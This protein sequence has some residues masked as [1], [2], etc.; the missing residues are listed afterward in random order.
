MN[1][2]TTRPGHA[3]L[4]SIA[5]T[6]APALAP[7]L[8]F[9]KW[10]AYDPETQN[11][12]PIPGTVTFDTKDS[13]LLHLERVAEAVNGVAGSGA[14]RDWFS[15]YQGGLRGLGCAEPDRLR[16]RTLWRLVVGTA[17]NPALETG[18]TLH[19]LLGVPY[20]PGSAVKGLA[21]HVAEA[22][23]AERLGVPLEEPPDDET[24][25]P[26]PPT[27]EGA[28]TKLLDAA[29]RVRAVFG[30]L[31]VDRATD[32]RSG[33]PRGPHTGVSVLR[34]WQRDREAL[35]PAVRSQIRDLLEPTGGAVC[36]YDAV[37]VPGSAEA[38]AEVDVMTPHYPDYYSSKGGSP[39]SDDQDP[40]P[41]TF[42]AVAPGV[43]LAFPF[44]VR[45][46]PALAERL[47]S[48]QAAELAE[49]WLLHGLTTWGAGAKTAAGYGYFERTG[50]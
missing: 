10:H 17:T 46:T 1:E 36:F 24:M 3:G 2:W 45:R 30:S 37:P 33:R 25:P 50:G 7:G 15:R 18:L 39:P 29:A 13:R 5:A 40:R 22:E 21:H 9:H 16:A 20:L 35:A 12:K 11:G 31:V 49:R 43:E 42:L 38:V 23:L 14:Y 27:E 4:P 6:A 8:L 44:R 26:A 19:P 34:A 28:L 48:E 32:S 41:V 47:T